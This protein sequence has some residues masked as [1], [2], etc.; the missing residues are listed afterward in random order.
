MD[1]E[2]PIEHAIEDADASRVRSILRTLCK[3][4][5]EAREVVESRLV[6]EESEVPN[7]HFHTPSDEK[8]RGSA[9]TE[10]RL[11]A[12]SATT[13]APPPKR[14][15]V[16]LLDILNDSNQNNT[17]EKPDVA[18][19]PPRKL[20]AELNGTGGK[21][22]ARYAI[23]EHC[24]AEFDVTL[25]RPDACVWHHGK[26]G[27]PRDAARRLQCRKEFDLKCQE[28]EACKYHDGKLEALPEFWENVDNDSCHGDPH[29]DEFL[30][31]DLPEGYGYECCQGDA[32]S[33]GCRVGRHKENDDYRPEKKKRDYHWRR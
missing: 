22:R 8:F 13:D 17:S 14:M 29:Y 30:K 3:Q 15:R 19:E 24:K 23:C 32:R 1:H 31:E 10:T 12:D 5:P 33:Q 26:P 21:K 11:G 6:V 20:D 25:N 27:T 9:R 18:K 4:T 16:D 7:L 28:H 2:E